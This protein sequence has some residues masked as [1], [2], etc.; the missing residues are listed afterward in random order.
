[1]ELMTTNLTQRRPLRMP[2][3]RPELFFFE[4]TEFR[5][6]FPERVVRH[7]EEN[8]PPPP[9]DER[10]ARE[11]Q[12]LCQLLEPLRPLPAPA[13]LPV[14]L[15]A[16]L[17]LSFPLLLSALP[18]WA[19]D[20]SRTH[21]QAAMDAWRRWLREHPAGA[22]S[23]AAAP[24]AR[25][26]AEVCW[27]SDGGISSNFPI[28]FFD[29]PLPHRP[30]FAINLRGFHPDYPQSKDETKNVYL[31]ERSGGGLLEWWYR[32]PVDDKGQLK[33]FAES[34]VRTMQNRVDEAQMRVPGYRD[35][36]VHVSTSQL[37]G[38]MNLNMPPPVIDALTARG[39]EAA[40][41]LVARFAR[42]PEHPGDLSWDSHRWT[43]FRSSVAAIA[44][45]VNQVKT[46]YE[47]KPEVDGER[48]YKEL[49]KRPRGEPPR[50]YQFER[51]VLRSS[52]TR[53]SA[54]LT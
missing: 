41:R 42:P 43:R 48:T 21:N 29:A 13:N 20:W 51:G 7:L 54:P 37:E 8:P 36:V 6:L 1:L 40:R 53:S 3:V 23:D 4:P 14:V 33:A 10:E 45:L 44:S 52:R 39:R 32:Y 50:T 2:W 30:T 5:R 25:P 22:I 34:I 27:F 9:D 16:R 35:R 46:G 19:I 12:L 26:Y 15:G 11:W 31:P 47:A 18:L 49:V 28:H 24:E 17:S 38:G